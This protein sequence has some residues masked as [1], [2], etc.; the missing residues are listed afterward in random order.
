MTTPKHTLLGSLMRVAAAV[1]SAGA[2][3]VSILSYTGMRAS[4]ARGDEAPPASAERAHRLSLTPPTDTATAIGDSIQLAALVTD[5]RGAALVGVA[6]VWTSADPAVAEVDQAG[7]VLSRG[8]GSTTVIVRVGPHEARARVTVDPRPVVLRPGDTLIR[9]AEGERGRA[10]A[11]AV[12]ARG[13]EIAGAP[14]R[15][16]A[17][18]AAVASV[19]SLG[20]VRGVSPGRSTLTVSLGELRADVPV[21]VAPVPASITL[22]AGEDQRGPG[23]RPL[24]MPVTAQ[25]VSRTGRPIPGVAATFQVR[26]AGSAAPALDTADAR[27]TVSTVW[28]LDPSPGRQQLAIAVDGVPVSPVVTAEADP[29]PANTKVALASE[30]APATAGDSLPEPVAV[31]VT[32]TMGVA[33]ADLPVAW[34]ALD[35]GRLLPLGARTDSLGEARALWRLGP[36]AGRQRIRVQ[37]GNARSMPP[38]TGGT[39]AL[40]GRADSLVVRGDRQSG[41]VGAPLARPILVRALDRAGNPVPGVS[42]TAA[43]GAGSVGDSVIR[44]DSSGAARLRWTLGREAGAQKLSVGLAEGKSRLELTAT[45]TAGAPARLAFVGAPAS[46]T[47]GRPLAN[48]LVVELTDGFG[49]PVGG[50]R[51]TLATTSGALS[52]AR[53]ETDKAGRLRVKWTPGSKAGTATLTARLAGSEVRVKQTISVTPPRPARS[54]SGR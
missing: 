49:N 26:G 17:A 15:W 48:G 3:L 14:L 53:A 23:G 36:R 7:T 42:L 4:V 38:F 21:E 2:A 34:S 37:V 54:G 35:G 27:G 31:R 50:Q 41:R 30:I 1:L 20:E 47:A 9:V 29:L 46:A 32:D 19:D 51:V 28:T 11:V 44:T 45:A 40:A 24:A 22:L 8:P 16:Q 43:P 5:D 18:D 13:N 52:P 33:L 25:I 12:D 39:V 6:P 10:A